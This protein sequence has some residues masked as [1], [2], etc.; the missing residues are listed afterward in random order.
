MLDLD[1]PRLRSHIGRS[2]GRREDRRLLRGEGRF[3]DDL[4]PAHGL[5]MAV[6]RSPFPH[7][8]IVSA[9]ISRALEL[10]GVRHILLGADVVRRSGP[11]TLLR[12]ITEVPPLAYH[13]MAAEVALFEGQPVVSVAAASRHIAEDALELIDIEFEPLDQCT[14]VTAAVAPGAPALH[15][16]L[17]SNLLATTVRATGDPGQ[18]LAQADVVVG[19]VFTINR[20]TAL[21][22]EGRGVVAEYNPGTGELV[23]HSSSQTPHLNRKQLAEILRIDE[24]LVRVIAPMVGGGFG[25]KLGVYPED[26]LACLHSMATGRPVKWAEDRIEHFR[27]ST[28]ARE[29]RHT[30]QLG[31]TSDGRIQVLRDVIDIDM[32]AY[33]SAFGPPSSATVTLTG[34]YLVQNCHA[35]RRVV[36]TNKPPVGAYRGYGAPESNFVCEVLMDRMARRLG[37]DPLEFRLRNMIQ[38]EQLPLETPSGAIYDG[39]DYPRCLRLAAERAGYDQMK[40]APRGPGADGRYRGIGLAAYIE[41]TGYPGSRW[42]GREGAAFGAYESVTLRG[43]RS[44]SVNCYSGIAS[45][46]QGGETALAQVVAEVLGMDLDRVHVHV[47]DTGATPAAGGSFSSRTMIAISG[48][49][50][51][52]AGELSARILTIAAHLLASAHPDEL[53]IQGSEVVSRAD[54]EVRMPLS[55]VFGAGISGHD[56]PDGLA[57]GLEATAHFDPPA[58]AYGSGA[59][60]CVVA[61]D[62]RTGEFG[63]ERFVLVHD[64]GTQINP[65]LVEGQVLGGL[66]QALGAALMEE[67]I[68]DPESGQLTNGTMMDYFAPTA[69][70]LPEFELGHIE[71]PSP[72][73]PFGVRGVGEAGTIAPNAAIANAICDALRDFNVVI[74][75]LPL[76]PERV[77]TAITEAREERR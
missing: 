37:L 32:G 65:V 27:S 73:T 66:A 1:E 38:P 31:A 23:V 29:A 71:T 30:A 64:C 59:A 24:G 3:L 43:T 33:H 6:G 69:A 11:L 49:A 21:P 7:T 67:L 35:E 52:A 4:Q 77:W 48:A 47:G 53:A 2:A 5:H 12:P 26:L 51:Q 45:F 72:V 74:N 57:P 58:S 55:Q 40:D 50:Q 25:M 17:D 15:Q 63:I 42:L 10:D 44:G 36:A 76:T 56:L 70:D 75:R 9:D 19:D 61:V 16:G 28:Q 18:A 60:A 41:K 46:G 68:F 20:V 54:P 22:M 14:D 39:G 8:R 62:P 13:A 34:P